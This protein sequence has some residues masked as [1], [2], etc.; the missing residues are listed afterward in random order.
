MNEAMTWG[1]PGGSLEP[2][3]RS[4]SR[5]SGMHIDDRWYARR[6]AGIREAIE[7]AGDPDRGPSFKIFLPELRHGTYV[8]PA[9]HTNVCLPFGLAHALDDFEGVWIRGIAQANSYYFIYLISERVDG[10]LFL[11]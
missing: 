7:E 9:V 2:A 11:L 5:D 1:F 3:E 4:M 8:A 6:R 10:V